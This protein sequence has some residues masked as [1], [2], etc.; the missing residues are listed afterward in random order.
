YLALIVFFAPTAIMLVVA[1]L[2]HRFAFRRFTK[3]IAPDSAAV[4]SN[5]KRR[6]GGMLVGLRVRT[7]IPQGENYIRFEEARRELNRHGR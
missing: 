2:Y 4:V 1:D 3:A 7:Q 6:L 5:F